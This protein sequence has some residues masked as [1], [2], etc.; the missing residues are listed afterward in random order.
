MRR[1]P[2]DRHRQKNSPSGLASFGR[3]SR[4]WLHP[5]SGWK[6]S[7]Q[8][9]GGHA[10]K[11]DAEP[12]S[13]GRQQRAFIPAI[14]ITAAT[15]MLR[16]SIGTEVTALTGT[17]PMLLRGSLVY[18]SRKRA[19]RDLAQVNRVP[20]VRGRAV[21][22]KVRNRRMDRERTEKWIWM[23][24]ARGKGICSGS[25]NL[26]PFAFPRVDGSSD[27]IRRRVIGV[28]RVNY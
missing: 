9:S 16:R 22:G 24:H 5:K 26:P 18:F 27:G 6:A 23:T 15:S 3:R 10:G 2:P 14:Q 19:A 20:A 13:A 12:I 17:F 1:L 28:G 21:P 25:S 8:L 7:G 4:V 11:A